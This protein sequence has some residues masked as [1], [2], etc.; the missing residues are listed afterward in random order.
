MNASAV[1]P[2]IFALAGTTAALAEVIHT[3][4]GRTI[5][6]QLQAG[7][8]A[9]EADPEQ[10]L[11]IE[12]M[13]GPVA[14]V[15]TNL[16]TLESRAELLDSLRAA[17]RRVSADD[18]AGQLQLSDWALRKGLFDQA[19]DLADRALDTAARASGQPALELPRDLFR[20]PQNGLT[21]RDAPDPQQAWALLVQCI[22]R[23]SSRALVAV[24]LLKQQS[25]HTDLSETLL[26]G[27]K[28]PRPR[29]RRV[30]LKL[31]AATVPDGTI[32]RVIDR[33]LFDRDP[34]VRL[35][36][37]HA[38]QAYH[39]EGV[40]YPLIRALGQSRADLRLA[41]MDAL[42]IL[43]DSRAVG[44]LIRHMRSAG[45]GKRRNHYSSITH[46][47][48]V[49]DFDVEIAQAAVIA[50]PIV[51]VVQH[52]TVHDVGVA[53]VFERRIPQAEVVRV[54]ALLEFLTGQEFGTDVQEWETWLA[55]TQ[56][57]GAGTTGEPDES[58]D[59]R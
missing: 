9:A 18:W 58:G 4:D 33:M 10:P 7:S 45:S 19:L 2:L 1:L 17:R 40:V 11:L 59:S 39:D 6:G 27:L 44:S 36:A 38:V 55:G 46:T 15:R 14:V 28:D 32:E 54:G 25:A 56:R 22:G 30:A 21:R 29:L 24:E 5:V 12:T 3:K 47:S 53:G 37:A 8:S 48:I 42:E 13:D 20:V 50:Q 52:G 35:A 43:N 34:S 26:R 49:G 57:P 41:A 51:D 23:S 16:L 31:L